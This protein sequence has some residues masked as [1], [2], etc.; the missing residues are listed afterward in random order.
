M[1]LE[2]YRL[3]AFV[4]ALVTQCL[5]VGVREPPIEQKLQVSSV[6]RS[7]FQME[8][9]S[10]IPVPWQE[11]ARKMDLQG[12]MNMGDDEIVVLSRAR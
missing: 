2:T 1:G 4:S 12:L 5:F 11:V 6:P 7:C 9:T 10:C 3:V 8:F